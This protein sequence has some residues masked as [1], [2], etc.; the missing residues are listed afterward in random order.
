MHPA[1]A[2]LVILPI[3]IDLVE[4]DNAL[5]ARTEVVSLCAQHGYG[6]TKRFGD[7]CPAHS[8]QYGSLAG[9]LCKGLWIKR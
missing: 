7:R 6:G 1:R 3:S 9:F 8:H 5:T 4:A 2:S